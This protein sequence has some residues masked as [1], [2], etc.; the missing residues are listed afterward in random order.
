MTSLS[1]INV[2]GMFLALKMINA[3]LCLIASESDAVSD[4]LDR[5]Y[6]H[7]VDDDTAMVVGPAR[8]AILSP[9]VSCSIS[10]LGYAALGG[11][12]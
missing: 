9:C 1:T 7:N 8:V 12:R 10:R 5:P 3:S 4:F 2:V 6:G 11:Q